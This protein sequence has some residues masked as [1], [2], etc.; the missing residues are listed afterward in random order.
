MFRKKFPENFNVTNLLHTA[1]NKI[2]AEDI[3][4]E[5]DGTKDFRKAM[6]N[7]YNE[8]FVSVDTIEEKRI[9]IGW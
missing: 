2:T 3:Y 8:Y 9:P 1:E 6:L 4:I 5:M 7:I